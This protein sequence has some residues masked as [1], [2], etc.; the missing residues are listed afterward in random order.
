MF[1]YTESVKI[2]SSFKK[3]S[4][5][6]GKITSRVCHGFI[7]KINGYTDYFF[8]NKTV[9]LNAG[10]FIFLPKG[11][12]YEYRPSSECS[13]Y[14][15]INFEATLDN[16]SPQVFS[17]EIFHDSNYIIQSFSELWKFGSASD[18]YRCCALVYELLS[19]VS[20]FEHPGTK[21]KRKYALIDPAVEYL[22]SHLHDSKL[23]TN[24]LHC[25]CGISDTY[26]RKIFTARFNMTPREYVLTRR[27]T[28]A[29]AIIES[30]D[31]DSIREVSFSVGYCDP[32]YFS[33][34]FKK[35][36]GFP[37]SNIGKE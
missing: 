23:K 33:K 21:K 6:Y 35:F 16:A 7:F 30:G 3:P 36:Y 27:I 18:K 9:R 22:K 31:Y 8:E 10:E 12:S 26:F 13:L 14:T 24:K 15:S 4:K 32:L 19:C 25:L 1:G 5:M 37:P 29:K 28:D 20:K 2:I 17:Q 34:A 11:T